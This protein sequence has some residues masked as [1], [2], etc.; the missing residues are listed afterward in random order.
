MT[1]TLL[2]RL[3]LVLLLVSCDFPGLPGGFEGR[4]RDVAARWQGSA[5]DRAWRTGFVPLEVLNPQGWARVGRVPHWAGQS[6]HNRIWRLATTLP[7]RAPSPAAVR[8]P[9]GSVSHL[10]LVSAAAEYTKFA[11]ATHLIEDPCPARGCRP[12]VITGVTLGEVPVETSRGEV[13]VPAWR[14]AVE[15]VDQPFVRVA[16][17]PSAV[18][19]RPRRAQGEIEQVHAYDLVAGGPAALTVRYGFGVCENVTGLPV[20]ETGRVVVVGVASTPTGDEVCPAI[21]KVATAQVT[22]TRPLGDRIVLD[23]GSGLPVL[24]GLHR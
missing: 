22:L 5:A 3:S 13:R 10:P 15:G 24:R 21:L 8:W 23:A 16:V 2:V 11:G 17:D 18:T 9:D 4:A 20:H 14:Y 19:E 7:T 12:L 6:A 1:R